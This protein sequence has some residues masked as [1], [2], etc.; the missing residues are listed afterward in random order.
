V[1]HIVNRGGPPGRPPNTDPSVVV[2]AYL[3][4]HVATWAKEQGGARTILLREY[5]LY[6]R[7]LTAFNLHKY[8]QGEL[9]EK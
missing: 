6:Q 4:K 5:S 9:N 1:K 8:N 3:P 2:R 7:A